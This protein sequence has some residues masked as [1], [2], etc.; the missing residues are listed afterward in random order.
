MT[1][2]EIKSRKTHRANRRA[3][4][5]K[6]GIRFEAEVFDA[7]QQALESDIASIFHDAHLCAS[8][9]GGKTVG[10]KDF[11]LVAQIRRK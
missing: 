3:T 5:E 9:R 11:D 10:K 6:P 7:L 8:H 2:K 4:P 1:A